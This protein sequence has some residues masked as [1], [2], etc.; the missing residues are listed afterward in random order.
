VDRRCGV[1]GD[2]VWVWLWCGTGLSRWWC[3]LESWMVLGWGDA[4]GHRGD[5][6]CYMVGRRA[7]T[8]LEPSLPVYLMGV[9]GNG[10]ITKKL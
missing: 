1:I 10:R 5:R 3:V 4:M 6:G 2:G 9:M 7:M 8:S